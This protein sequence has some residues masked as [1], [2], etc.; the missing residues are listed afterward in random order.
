MG[1]GGY[2]YIL[3]SGH[4]CRVERISGMVLKLQ[5]HQN[6]LKS[7][8]KLELPGSVLDVSVQL[9]GVWVKGR[10]W[11][12]ALLTGSLLLPLVRGLNFENHYFQALSNS[13]P[14]GHRLEEMYFPKC[15]FFLCLI[16]T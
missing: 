3:Y 13:I 8:L 15:V 14:G 12:F 1:K 9:V 11:E 7:L 6:H 10:A 2:G 16:A 5:H 4:T